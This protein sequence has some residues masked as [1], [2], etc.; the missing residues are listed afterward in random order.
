V[1]RQ[2][3]RKYARYPSCFGKLD[4]RGIMRIAMKYGMEVIQCRKPALHCYN[5]VGLYGTREQM[6]AV[7][8]EWNRHGN[9]P[10]PRGFKGYFPVDLKLPRAQWASVLAA[11]AK[12]RAISTRGGSRKCKTSRGETVRIPPGYRELRPRELPRKTDIA[13]C[14]AAAVF[15]PIDWESVERLGPQ[16]FKEAADLILRKDSPC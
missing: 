10:K 15:E 13:W 7:E 12:E 2:R 8:A 14:Y 11:A 5:E 9:T 16:R 4:C 3:K 6:E 1:P